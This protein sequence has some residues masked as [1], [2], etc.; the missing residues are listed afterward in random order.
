MKI[1]FYYPIWMVTM[2]KSW[3]CPLE[4]FYLSNM[5]SLIRWCCRWRLSGVRSWLLHLLAVQPRA[6]SLYVF[7]LSSHSY[8]MSMISVSTYLT[9]LLWRWCEIKQIKSLRKAQNIISNLYKSVVWTVAGIGTRPKPTEGGDLF[10]K[11][12]YV[13]IWQR[14]HK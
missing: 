7:C 1:T 3:T 10:F 13:F 11:G 2:M 14:E 9:G 6:H 12:F 4:Y 8:K 5:C